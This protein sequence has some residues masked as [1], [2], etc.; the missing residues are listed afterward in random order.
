[1]SDV[2]NYKCPNCG[3][4]LVYKGDKQ[5]MVCESCDGEFTMEEVKAAAEKDQQNGRSSDMTWS[6]QA[7]AE[8]RDEEGKL[9]GYTCP[10]CGAEIVA[11]ENTAATECPYCGNKAIMPKAFDGMYKPDCMIP[12]KVDKAAAQGA[13]LNFYKGKRLLHDAF[14]D[15][16]RIKNINGL[17]VPF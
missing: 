2:M 16:N 17:Y 13:L 8:I 11:D 14:V 1:M 6:Q 12:F 15:S 3:A 10:S 7:P 5:K 4:P 9:K